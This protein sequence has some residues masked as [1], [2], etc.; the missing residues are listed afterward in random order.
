MALKFHPDKNKAPN[1]K[2]LFGIIKDAYDTLIDPAS[3]RAYD[4]KAR[5][6]Y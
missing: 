3:R 1:A 6:M 4:A 2:E 5:R